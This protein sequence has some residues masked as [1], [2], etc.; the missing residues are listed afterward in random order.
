MHRE[1]E[2]AAA[3]LD[4]RTAVLA[5]RGRQAATAEVQRRTV[6]IWTVGGA[7]TAMDVSHVAAVIPFGG[8]APVP[9]AEPA[10]LG[11][12]GWSG[13][14]YSVIAMRAL[15]GSGTA[16]V[17]ESGTQPE[18]PAHLLLLRGAAPHLALAVDGVLGRFDLP[19][20]GPTLDHDGHL[21]SLLD[22]AALR[23]RLNRAAVPPH[24]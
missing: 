13:R 19:D 20:T 8:Y 17:A 16:L 18:R 5:A 23:A 10:C 1:Q 22:P 15:A 21:V 7:R 2:R 6:V 24:P 11:V 14:I 9:T 3:L 4:R 12:I